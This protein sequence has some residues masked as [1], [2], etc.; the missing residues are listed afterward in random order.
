MEPVFGIIG[1]GNISRY[2]FDGLAKINAKI[3]RVADVDI[4]RAE[5]YEKRF[6]A[7]SSTDYKDVIQDPDVTVVSILG[8]AKFHKSMCLEAI[9]AGKDVICEKTMTSNPDEAMEIVKAVKKKGTLFFTAYMKRFFPAVQKAHELLGKMGTPFSMHARS[10]QCWPGFIDAATPDDFQWIV[11]HYGGAVLKCCGSHILD[12]MLSFFGRPERV[13]GNIDY[14]PNSNV[15]RRA[16][17]MFEYESSKVA[18][19]ETVFHPLTRIGYERNC[20]DERIEINC[21]RGRLDIYTVKWD[22]PENNAALLVHYDEATQTS[23]EYRFDAVNPF[24]LEMEYISKC[25][26]E[27]RQDQPDVIDGFNVDAVI[28]AIEKSHQTKSSVEIDWCGL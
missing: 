20:W 11:D 12:L 25:L 24:H 8:P 27:R 22:Q 5:T 4:T 7:K 15:D 3:A 2:H 13:Y 17:A 19:F 6:N 9:E 10:Y 21:T 1:C 26:S 23:T 18:N 16:S 14:I 28:A